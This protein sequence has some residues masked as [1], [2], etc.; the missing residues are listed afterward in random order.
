MGGK[1]ATR[2]GGFVE[3]AN[4]SIMR[5]DVYYV[6]EQR[7]DPEGRKVKS[8]YYLVPVYNWQILD[9]SQDMPMNA[10]K[11]GLEENWPLMQA[12]DF[13]FSLFKDS[14]VQVIKNGSETLFE[15]Y[16]A[17]V[18]RDGAKITLKHSQRRQEN[19][20]KSSVLGVS[21]L[22]KFTIN[23]LGK[24]YRVRREVWPGNHVR[25]KPPRRKA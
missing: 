15:G 13:L 4:A 12:A 22:Q 21:S 5:T 7:K 1:S 18:D 8:G 6:S 17:S 19:I 14:W 11:R 25:S 24:K 3:N 10:V 23:R 20:F 16:F 2:A 9:Q